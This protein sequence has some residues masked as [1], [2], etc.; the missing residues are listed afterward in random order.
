M[1]RERGGE[2]GARERLG[3]ERGVESGARERENGV[4]EG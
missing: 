1:A 3:R 4:K 2:S